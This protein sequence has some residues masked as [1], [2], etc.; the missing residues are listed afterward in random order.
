MSLSTTGQPH[1]AR[2]GRR[3][4]DLS[5]E[6]EHY[7]KAAKR[8]ATTVERTLAELIRS[9]SLSNPVSLDEVRCDNTLSER[10]VR[11]TVEILR[12]IFRMPIGSTKG[13]P[14]GFFWIRTKKE[15]K[16]AIR[17]Y[18]SGART[19]FKNVRRFVP[20]DL[21]VELEGQLPL[22]DRPSKKPSKS[23]ARS[24]GPQSRRGA[25]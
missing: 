3:E 1:N 18:T 7:W 13:K 20:T 23:V 11:S 19:V 2:L 5:N 16:A 25:R 9:G 22:F 24:E 12:T 8:R 10:E 4:I 17:C 6:L 21:L 14:S 15:A